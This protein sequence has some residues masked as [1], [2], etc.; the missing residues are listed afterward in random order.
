MT[1]A[2]VLR[3]PDGRRAHVWQGGDPDRSGRVLLPR[4][5][6]H[7]AR[8]A[9]RRRGGRRAG[10][11]LVAVSRPGY[12]HSD[13]A[14]SGHLSVAADTVAVADLLGIDRFA[15]LGMSVGGPY[16]LACAATH[17]AGSRRPAVVAAPAVVPALDPPWPRDDLSSDQQQFFAG[18]AASSVDECV[19]LM[20]PEFEQYVA[21][22]APARPRRRSTGGALAGGLH[23]LDV[24]L[25]EALPVTE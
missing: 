15:V 16:A 21:G 22:V 3:L 8:R 13:A 14:A 5:P 6:R 18:L 2:D 7:P 25:V 11:R 12:G 24:P 20:R 19:E 4:M 17:P 1:D 23:P 9:P 10:V